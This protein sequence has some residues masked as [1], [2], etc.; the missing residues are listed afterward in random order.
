MA[1]YTES[2]DLFHDI[3]HM[4]YDSWYIHIYIY[5][6]THCFLLWHKEQLARYHPEAAVYN[7]SPH[8]SSSALKWPPSKRNGSCTPRKLTC[9]LQRDHFQFKD[10]SSNPTIKFSGG[11]YSLTLVFR[12]EENQLQQ[13]R[14]HK[15]QQNWMNQVC[16]ILTTLHGYHQNPQEHAGM[17]TSR[18]RD[19]Y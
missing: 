8:I 1:F 12:G 13:N 9:P 19:I 14:Q 3:M 18:A 15:Q 11:W 16:L 10:L 6:Y 7:F 5:V 2:Q 17:G 4:K